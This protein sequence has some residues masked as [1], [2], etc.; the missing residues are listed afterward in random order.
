MRE[1]QPDPSGHRFLLKALSEAGNEL[2]EELYGCSR[3]LL[4]ASDD[5]G[6]S[7]RLIA[8]HTRA[9]EE[10]VGEY[11]QII[12]SRREPE[13]PVIDTEAV[14]DDPDACREDA[15]HAALMYAHLRR[16]LQYT[17][18]DLSDRQW[19]RTGRHP[20]R[21]DISIIQL[22]RELHLHDLEFLWRARRIKEQQAVH[23]A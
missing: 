20:Y 8:A 12:L 14:R 13:L 19:E 11:V 15:E 23:R 22:A 9:H 16:T 3:R 1:I 7:I 6:W 10:M 2:A 21:G 4:D 5:D 18:W 17:L